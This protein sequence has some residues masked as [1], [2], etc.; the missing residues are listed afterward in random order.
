MMGYF[1][2]MTLYVCLIRA[3]IM[4]ERQLPY[5]SEFPV[6]IGYSRIQ[7][8]EKLCSL[9]PEDVL[10]RYRVGD[11]LR[12]ERKYAEA[13]EWFDASIELD[14]VNTTVT[15]VD[16]IQHYIGIY[17]ICQHRFIGRRYR[18]LPCNDFDLCQDCFTSPI[19]LQHSPR[20][21]HEFFKIPS[22]KWV[23]K[24]VESGKFK[25]NDKGEPNNN[26]NVDTQMIKE[27]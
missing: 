8:V 22:D 10:L 11:V 2:P 25:A 19:Q 20:S 15:R 13:S 27:T 3:E 7:Y 26:G 16:D 21:T 1:A 12:K 14:T 18:C 4:Q 24:M 6:D 9:Y 23:A 17:D 5:D